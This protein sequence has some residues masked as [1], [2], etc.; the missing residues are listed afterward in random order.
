HSADVPYSELLPSLFE[1][2]AG[3]FMMQCRSERD[4]ESVYKLVGEHSREDANGVPQVV[5][6]GVINPQNP[7]VESAQEVCDELVAAAKHI[8]KER[9]GATDACGSP[10]STIDENPLHGRPDYARDTA[11]QKTETRVAAT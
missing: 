8:P 10:P 11:S 1:L 9:L 7:R 4:R 5:F 3:Y 2:N 6:V